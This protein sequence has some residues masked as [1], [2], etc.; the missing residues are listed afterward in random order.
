MRDHVF[1]YLN[2]KPIQAGGS[3]AFLMLSDYLRERRRLTGTKIVCAEGDCGACSVLVGR[4]EAGRL[5]Y[6]AVCSCIL[7]VSQVDGT[8]VVTVEGLREGGTAGELNP[9]QKAFVVGHGAQCGFCT[10]GFVV[11]LQGVAEGRGET[12]AACSREC[13]QRELVG[14]LC[15]CTGY[16]SILDAAGQVDM[17]AVR[18]V[19]ELYA[20]PTMAA[21]LAA[22]AG[23]AFRV[24]D[25]GRTVFK[26]VSIGDA[27]AFKGKHPDAMVLAGSTDVGV[28]VNKRKT[29]LATV[30]SVAGLPG[31]VTVTKAGLE[32]GAAGTIRELEEAA[33]THIPALAEFLQWFASPLIRSNAT[34]VG[35]VVT[36]SPIGDLLPVLSVLEAEVRLVG[37]RGERRVN[38]NAFYTGYRKSV[39]GSDELVSGLRIPLPTSESVLKCYKVSKRKDVDISTVS[40]AFCVSGP[41]EKVSAVRIALGGVAATV[42]RATAAELLLVGNALTRDGLVR[43]GVLAERAVSPLSDFR[44]SA[45]YRRALV[46]NL[47]VKFAND[48]LDTMGTSNT[49]GAG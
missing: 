17:S 20:E 7:P 26:P 27:A 45:E 4:A 39:L 38:L 25:A 24:E 12:G 10:P 21:D 2:G 40:A 3:D 47:F 33:R 36:G 8:H 31:G 37:P 30:L 19:G 29:R 49:S 1:F 14:N 18:K 44:G 34:V 42:V 13:L 22:A 46:R 11:A 28:G 5:R 32:V 48:T 15:R 41:R 9:I 43:A 23:E 35:N 16:A 6:R